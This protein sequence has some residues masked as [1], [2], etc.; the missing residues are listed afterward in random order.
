MKNRGTWFDPRR[1][2]QVLNGSEHGYAAVF[3]KHGRLV[4]WA[5]TIEFES[6]RYYQIYDYRPLVKWISCLSSKQ[7]VEVR[8]L[9]GRPYSVS[10]AEWRRIG[11]QIR[12]MQVQILS[13]TPSFS[14]VYSVEVRTRL[15]E[16][17]SMGSLPIRHPI[18]L[19]GKWYT[20]VL[21]RLNHKFDPC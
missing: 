8:S 13:L 16:S 14:G 21:V 3:Y 17:R 10:V 2:H 15:C 5:G 4:R 1:Q 11:L 18:A 6:L 7:T 19:I 20:T 9:H 12:I